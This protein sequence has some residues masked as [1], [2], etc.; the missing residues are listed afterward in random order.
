MTHNTRTFVPA[1]PVCAHGNLSRQPP[2]GLLQLIF[3]P[4]Q[5]W[6]HIALDFVTGIPHHRGKR[7]LWLWSIVSQWCSRCSAP[8]ESPATSHRTGGRRSPCGGVKPSAQFSGWR[9]VSPLATVQW[10]D[11]ENKELSGVWQ[12]RTSTH[13]QWVEFWELRTFRFSHGEFRHEPTFVHIRF[14]WSVLCW[15]SVNPLR[16]L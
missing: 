13:L 7:Q 1:C 4:Q 12:C 11:G 9:S 10:P 2:T 8:T 5:P 14:H 16:A 3:R 6:F 15:I